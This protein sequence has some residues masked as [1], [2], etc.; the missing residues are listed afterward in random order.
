[1]RVFDLKLSGKL[2]NIQGISFH[3]L[4]GNPR[5]VGETLE[6]FWEYIFRS[7]Q[8]ELFYE[9]DVVNILQNLKNTCAGVSF[10]IKLQAKSLQL[11]WKGTQHKWCPVNFAKFS[12]IP[13]LRNTCK[14]LLLYSATLIS[15]WEKFA[16]TQFI[17][18]SFNYLY[19]NYKQKKC[20]RFACKFKMK[21]VVSNCLSL[22]SLFCFYSNNNA[23]AFTDHFCDI[24]VSR[25]LYF[26]L[27]YFAVRTQTR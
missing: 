11:Y 25:F 6:L 14:W 17:A 10:L 23:S 21:L 20:F 26:A 2:G 4:A 18:H 3:V 7:S 13:T 24:N 5:L 12:R 16:C 19:Q 1:M 15:T 9:K 22:D 8:P 27:A